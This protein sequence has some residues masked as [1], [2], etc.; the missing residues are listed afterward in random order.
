MKAIAHR[1]YSAVAP[2]NILP[3]FRFAG[4]YSFW[5]AGC[6]VHLTSDGVWVICHDGTIDRTTDGEG[7]I[8]DT[9][10][11][12]LM[13]Y[14]IDAGNNVEEYIDL[15]IPKFVDYLDICKIPALCSHRDK[16]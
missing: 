4:E 13:Q 12:D 16:I 8:M 2:E 6:D 9:T 5:G 15:K 11:D 3:A 1:G 7:R 10:Y 14:N